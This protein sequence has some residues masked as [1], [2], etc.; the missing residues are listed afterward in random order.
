[1]GKYEGLVFSV[2]D[3]NGKR[4]GTGIKASELYS[5][6]SMHNLNLKFEH[7][8]ESKKEIA[9]K[10]ASA[11]EKV[12]TSH[13]S[14]TREDLQAKLAKGGINL[15]YHEWTKGVFGVTFIDNA[16][17]AVFKGS[18]LGKGYSWNILQ[19][20]LSDTTIE[21][22]G[23]DML[24]KETINKGNSVLGTIFDTLKKD[25]QTGAY[26]ESQMIRKLPLMDLVSPLL[27]QMPQLE[28][29]A[30]EGV[31]K[32]F[33]EYKQG[34]LGEIEQKEKDYFKAGVKVV[35]NFLDQSPKSLTPADRIA[36]LN[37]H[38]YKLQSGS[39]GLVI[40]HSQG[41]HLKVGL[42]QEMSIRH[43]NGM[44]PVAN[45]KLPAYSKGEKAFIKSVADGKA[46]TKELDLFSFRYDVFKPLLSE[47]NKKQVARHL[48]E[49]YA[50]QTIDLLSA[51]G[52]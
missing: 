35:M 17:R 7:N 47:E 34:K 23:I 46:S 13:K 42:P 20:R 29:S 33:V 12:F 3:E 15:Q 10:T 43:F 5:K 27:K 26:F 8:K 49:K 44:L 11:I 41:P 4:V 14:I 19:S 30:G 31:V 40:T 37:K 24:D 32:G 22:R 45:E 36:F 6:T 52:M 16:N 39:G 2:T 48:T 18:E 1:N 38:G 28:R 50:K 9:P 51:P 25:E 21:K